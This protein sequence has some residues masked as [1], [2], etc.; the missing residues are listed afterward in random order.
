MKPTPPPDPGISVSNASFPP[1]PPGFGL[2]G[3]KHVQNLSPKINSSSNWSGIVNNYQSF[4]PSSSVDLCYRPPNMVDGECI[5][6]I[7]DSNISNHVSECEKL[8]VGGF[9]GDRLP[10]H[11]VKNT[12]ERACKI[13]GNMEMTIHGHKAYLMKFSLEEDRISALEYGPVFVSQTHFF[14]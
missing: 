12:V 3:D 7:K 14:V 8:L 1:F 11:L 9:F 10:Y 6:S 4:L 2:I 5:S 13:K